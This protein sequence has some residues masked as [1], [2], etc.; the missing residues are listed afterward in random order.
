MSNTQHTPGPWRYDY[1][2][3]YCGE[4][5]ASNGTSICSFTDEPSTN[6]AR[7]IAAAPELLEALQGM[8]DLLEDTSE[9]SR[10]LAVMDA[11]AAIA[12]ATG[13]KT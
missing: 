6:D 8:L 13:K 12:K 4:I 2:L 11:R 10:K 1:E 7:L 5:I 9:L 3:D